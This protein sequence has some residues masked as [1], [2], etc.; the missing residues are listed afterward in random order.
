MNPERTEI[1]N[2]S[3]PQKL[4][5]FRDKRGRVIWSLSGNTPEENEMIGIRNVQA[6]F[7]EKFPEFDELFPRGED[8]KVIE[9]KREEAKKFIEEKVG[10]QKKLLT[11]VSSSCFEGST[12]LAIMK[13]FTPWG[14]KFEDIPQ[15]DK[16]SGVYFD[17]RQEWATLAYLKKLTGLAHVTVQQ[18]IKEIQ[19]I[20]GYNLANRITVL[21][22]VKETLQKTKHLYQLPKTDPEADSTFTDTEGV[23]WASFKYFVSKYG[24]PTSG[25]PHYLKGTSSIFGRNIIGRKSRLYNLKEAS[26]KI[27]SLLALPQVNKKSGIYVDEQG[28][29]WVP[30]S[31]IFGRNAGSRFR[32]TKL[33]DVS[34]IEGRDRIG[35]KVILYGKTEVEEIRKILSKTNGR[36]RSISTEEANKELLKLL[37]QE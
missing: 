6:L 20:E 33:R 17:G 37:T 31:F 11:I 19:G 16:K 30:V 13:S 10:N 29:S 27:E 34:T 25:N 1:R 21:Y 22:P 15:I 24:L 5:V 4:E 12:R 23:I 35:R 8:G 2:L 3:A 9:D 28:K 7:L 26:E 36:D 14:L 32:R 18:R